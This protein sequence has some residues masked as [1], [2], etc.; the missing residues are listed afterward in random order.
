M[1]KRGLWVPGSM[2]VE[3]SF[4]VPFCFF[5]HIYGDLFL[6]LPCKCRHCH[7]SFGEELKRLNLRRWRTAYKGWGNS[8]KDYV[9]FKG[10]PAGG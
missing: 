9:G 5:R 1:S 10:K 2:T 3:A 4:I 8:G 7:R 6:L